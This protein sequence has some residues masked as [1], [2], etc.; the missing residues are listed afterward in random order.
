MLLFFCAAVAVF[1]AI[2]IL[3]AKNTVSVRNKD[4][5]SEF[6]FS[7]NIASISVDCFDVYP[8]ALYT[9]DDFASGNIAVPSE[10]DDGK[11]RYYT[12]R[13]LLDLDESTV[14]GLSGYSGTY[15]YKLWVDGALLASVGTPGDSLETMTPKTDYL[16]VYFTAGSSQ[17]E[18]V[19]QRSDFVHANGG[20]LRPQALGEQE[21]I[22]ALNDGI[23][24]RGAFM[25]GSLIMAALFFFGIF[26]FFNKR[27][28][29]LYFSLSCF[30]ITIRTLSIDHKLI[31]TL[32]PNL[33]WHISH[34][35]E[36]IGTLAFFFFFI[37]YVNLMFNMKSRRVL[38]IYGLTLV[39]SY[40]LLVLLTPALIY[41]RILPY[42]HIAS[43]IYLLPMIFLLVRDMV[44]D[45]KRF[46][47]EHFLILFGLVGYAALYVLEIILYHSGNNYHDLN[48][49]QI[50]VMFLVF[51]NTLA[52]VF[53]FSRTE[54][55]LRS[56]AAENA[57]LDKMYN[58]KTELMETISH[59]ARTP[60]AVLASYSSLIALELRGKGVDEQ[61]AADLDTIA[62]EAKRV[63]ELIESMKRLTLHST[64]T[65]KRISLDMGEVIRQTAG[66]YRH[67]LEREGVKLNVQIPDNLPPVVG[68]PEELTQVLLNLLQNAK[69]HTT[70]GSVAVTAEHDDDFVTVTVADTGE[71]ISA[72]LLPRIFE[73][74]VHGGGGGSGIGLTICFDVIKS[75]GGTIKIESEINKGTA[76]A[77]TLPVSKGETEYGE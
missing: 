63:A 73:R 57:A 24:F 4:E 22:S 39:I 41:T 66:L 53:N 56:L 20:R 58:L 19:I 18:I 17:T 8:K 50:G 31:M 71:G 67:I 13:L 72:E 25:V 75:H 34:K 6:D 43:M 29:F 35:A 26:L 40:F 74:G 38:N 5:L 70:Q 10:N 76:A 30:F 27:R 33:N 59:E 60:L 44:K 32:F 28:Q 55:E 11:A 77:F 23:Q 15:A 48:I 1:S 12:Y 46:M 49:M 9:P 61:T 69:N 3:T 47:T 42:M 65:A 51:A 45:R 68:S 64:E 14:Y 21:L 62:Y 36:S 2:D 37:L 16:T 54:N 52:L 7:E